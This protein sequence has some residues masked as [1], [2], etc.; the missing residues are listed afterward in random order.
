[1]LKYTAHQKESMPIESKGINS[2]L[3]AV[4]MC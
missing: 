1:M 4:I 2:D 3:A